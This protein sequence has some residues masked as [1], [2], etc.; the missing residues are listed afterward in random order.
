MPPGIEHY[1]KVSRQRAVELMVDLHRATGGLV[2]G[3]TRSNYRIEVATLAISVVTSGSLWALIA[4]SQPVPAAWI[5]AVFGTVIAF[6]KG[7]QL[8]FGP[9]NRIKDAYS[10][11]QDIG[12]AIAALRA[13]KGEVN[14]TQF[15]DQYKGFEFHLTKLEN[16]AAP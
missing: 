5:G 16:P 11:Y 15:W 2:S 4:G 9:K 6:L 10:L 12:K 7:Y 8:T 14:V 13:G 1:T 3:F